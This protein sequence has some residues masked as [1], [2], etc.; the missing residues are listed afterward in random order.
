[1]QNSALFSS[2]YEIIEPTPHVTLRRREH[3]KSDATWQE[4]IKEESDDEN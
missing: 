1:M 2:E 3:K 4:G